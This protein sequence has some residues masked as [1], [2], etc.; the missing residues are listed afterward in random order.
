VAWAGW[1]RAG[2][3]GWKR[4]ILID[5]TR[6]SEKN[7]KSQREHYDYDMTNGLTVYSVVALRDALRCERCER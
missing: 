7:A 4:G 6:R 3:F 1:G 2:T 5:L